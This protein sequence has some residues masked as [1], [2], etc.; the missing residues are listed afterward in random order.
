MVGGG[1]WPVA[2]FLGLVDRNHDNRLDWRD[3]AVERDG[4]EQLAHQLASFRIEL[5]LDGAV[6]F[7]GGGEF[8]GDVA[9]LDG[10]AHV[11]GNADEADDGTFG[12][13]HREL[14]GEAPAR[15]V[16]RVPVQFEMIEDRATG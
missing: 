10:R 6:A 9:G 3:L 16:R 13:A 1:A 8:H 12:V 2:P 11:A 14:G 5:L 15:F 4:A 7:E